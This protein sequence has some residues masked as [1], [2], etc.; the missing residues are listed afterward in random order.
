MEA[1]LTKLIQQAEEKIMGSVNQSAANL[2]AGEA[3]IEKD[4][5]SLGTA[6]GSEI[7]DMKAEIAA[8]LAAAGVPSSVVDGVTAKLST[9]DTT[10]QGLTGTVTAADPGT[11][12]TPPV[13]GS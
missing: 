11:T 9:L 1:R 2:Q 10:I 8:D 6:I 13:S 4:V 5:A 3:Q 12:S 7:A